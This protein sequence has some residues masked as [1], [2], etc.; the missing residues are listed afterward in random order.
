M[1]PM[2]TDL[3]EAR[4]L[5]ADLR[6]QFSKS[7]GA[8][9]RAV[10][11]DTDEAS[12]AFAHEAEG[13]K[14]WIKT[15]VGALQARL[16][17][18]GQE[19]E[20]KALQEFGTC[21]ADYEKLDRSILELAVENTN[22]KAQR[23]SFGPAREAADSFRDSLG[24]LVAAAAPKDRGQVELLVTK[25]VLALREI[26]VLQAPHIAEADDAVMTRMEGEMAVREAA[27][28]DA[29]KALSSLIDARA[30][31][32]L[33]TAVATLDRFASVSRELLKLSRRNSGVRSLELSL[34]RKP[35]LT[36]TCDNS[37]RSLQDA[38]DKD[39]FP[40]TR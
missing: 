8:S 15:D 30:R 19:P 21:F 33:A 6:V 16:R 39:R 12:I 5:A 10:M 40:A 18:I 4:R 24:T 32:Q 37:L 20:L 28:R 29:V 2:F 36:A 31:P 13:V 1:N 27:I 3:A 9:D 26:Q 11:A 14:G 23:L 25:A 22:L 34:R 38:L 35:T 17:Q 7:S